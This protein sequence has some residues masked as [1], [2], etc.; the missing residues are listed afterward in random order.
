MLEIWPQQ[1]YRP[2]PFQ[3]HS[4]IRA[5]RNPCVRSVH[6]ITIMVS[7]ERLQPRHAAVAACRKNNGDLDR[8]AQD[9]GKSVEFVSRWYNRWL[10]TKDVQDLPRKGR[11]SAF[12]PAIR[13]KAQ[14]LLDEKQSCTEVTAELVSMG[15]IPAKTHRSTTWRHVKEGKGAMECGHEQLLPAITASTMGKRLKFQEH[16]QQQATDWG[17]VLAIDSTIFRLG[18]QGGRRRVWRVKGSRKQKMVFNKGVKVHVYGGITAYGQTA[19]H[20]VS[21]TTG[22]KHSYHSKKKTLTGVGGAEVVDTLQSTLVPDGEDLFEA[23]GINDWQ[24]LMDKAPAHT[25]ATCQAWLKQEGIKVVDHW[26]SNSPDL[27]PIENVWGWMK[28][29][30]YKQNLQTLQELQAA[31]DEAWEAIP[32]VMLTKLMLG[33]PERLQKVKDLNGGYIDM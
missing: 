5:G 20:R 16:H 27:N 15:L 21:G 25:S 30:V 12:S 3:Q 6:L 4:L 31:V 14:A 18:K 13:E 17:K 22:L 24:L 26:P 1:S 29:R 10:E 28:C 7:A 2:L 19:L 32:P 23:M 33:M 9:V 8:T 11:P